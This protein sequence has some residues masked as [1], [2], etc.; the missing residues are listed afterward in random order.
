[1]DSIIWSSEDIDTWWDGKV[2]CDI[3]SRVKSAFPIGVP[4]AAIGICRFLADATNPN[5]SQND[6]QYTVFK[7]NM[8]D[9][10]LGLILPLINMGLKY[11]VNPSRYWIVGV[12]GCTGITALT[13]ASIPLYYLW[14][15]VLSL[16][17]SI[18][19]GTST[20]LR[21]RT[22]LSIGI[23]LR[24]WYIRRKQLNRNWALGVRNGVTKAEFRRLGFTVMTVIFV[25]FPLSIVVLV[26]YLREHLTA[27]DWDAYHGKFWWTII[28][29]GQPRA[30]WPLWVGPI[31]AFTSFLFIGTTRNARQF[32]EGCVEWLYDHSPK[33][34]QKVMPGMAKISE[35][36]KQSRT[37]RMNTA[38]TNFVSMVEWYISFLLMTCLIG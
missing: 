24:N 34:L 10:F 29:E 20:L 1:M 31:L 35:R 37:T 36:C 19:A 27:F 16:I 4:G 22:N 21:S 9:L 14:S 38:G 26:T 17:A 23:F 13:P 5:P 7:R 18:Y 12:N 25:Y 2:Y 28:K 15:P 32:Y 8:I 33:T 6:L 11:I 3:G 30:S